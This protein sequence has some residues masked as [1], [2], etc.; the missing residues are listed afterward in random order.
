MNPASLNCAGERNSQ[1]QNAAIGR[2]VCARC[3]STA[4]KPPASGSNLP[5]RTRSTAKPGS[6][7]TPPE[8]WNGPGMYR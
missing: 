5:K 4:A 2:P 3:A 1:A 7:A 8:Y 6:A